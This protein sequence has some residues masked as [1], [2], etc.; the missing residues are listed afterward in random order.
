MRKAKIWIEKNNREILLDFLTIALLVFST[1]P[2]CFFAIN[3][4]K[5]Y[6]NR[7]N[8]ALLRIFRKTLQNEIALPRSEFFKVPARNR[9]FF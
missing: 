6:L 3:Q 8:S 7:Q 1:R 4:E 5:F 2:V 9:F